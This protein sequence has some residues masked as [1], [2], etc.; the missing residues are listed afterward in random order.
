M[1]SSNRQ[2]GFFLFVAIWARC[3]RVKR[4]FFGGAVATIYGHGWGSSKAV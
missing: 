4:H 3:W 1:G 2:F